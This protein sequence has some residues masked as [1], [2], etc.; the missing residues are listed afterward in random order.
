MNFTAA[1]LNGVPSWN[2]TPLRRRKTQLVGLSCLQDSA[3]AGFTSRFS[4]SMTSASPMLTASWRPMVPTAWWKS[5]E[6][7]SADVAI[8][9]LPGPDA[10]PASPGG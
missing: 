1:A 7:G 10:A 8:V 2:F 5:P 9:S 3:R 6:F 4:S